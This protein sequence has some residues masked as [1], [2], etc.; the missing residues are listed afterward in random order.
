[1]AENGIKT[2]VFFG[3]IYPKISKNNIE[4]IINIF[5]SCGAKTIMLDKFNL[6]PGILNNLEQKIPG[7]SKKIISKKI[8]DQSFLM[9]VYQNI[10][11]NNDNLEIVLAF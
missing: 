1:M 8:K 3:P 11:N 7:I 2:S 4:K 5:A 9:D 10:K 6:K